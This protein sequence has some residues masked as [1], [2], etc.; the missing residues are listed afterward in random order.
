V[1]PSEAILLQPPGFIRPSLPDTMCTTMAGALS[2]A[3]AARN[4]DSLWAS[5]STLLRRC[6]MKK[7]TAKK[8]A[9]KTKPK[10]KKK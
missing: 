6:T 7:T 5:V 4:V 10:T 9:A 3:G 2:L 1:I 8:T